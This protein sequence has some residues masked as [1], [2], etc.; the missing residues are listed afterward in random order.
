MGIP[1]VNKKAAT[2]A[3]AL[4]DNWFTLIGFPEQIQSDKGKEFV[5]KVCKAMYS[6]FAVRKVQTSGWHPQANGQVERFNKTLAEMLTKLCAK[7]QVNWPNYLRTVVMEYNAMVHCSTGE[8]PY[9]M[10]FGRDFRFPLEIKNSVGS[11]IDPDWNQSRIALI[12]KRVNKAIR[13]NADRHKENAASYNKKRIPHG[14]KKGD[15]VIEVTMQST[16]KAKG[17]HKKLKLPGKGPYKVVEI[18]KDNNTVKLQ[19]EVSSSRDSWVVNV[20]RVR[21]FV[22]RP[23][24]MVDAK[25][26]TINEAT[27]PPQV[28]DQEMILELQPENAVVENDVVLKTVEQIFKK[29]VI[30]EPQSLC[31]FKSH[32]N[33]ENLMVDALVGTRWKCGQAIK[34]RRKGGY[35]A[36]VVG[37]H[38]NAWIPVFKLRLCKC[39]DSF[40]KDASAEEFL[41]VKEKKY[42]KVDNQ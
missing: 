12:A 13:R 32:L 29:P 9:W 5:A 6:V 34:F 38:I 35:S 19:D 39:D 30:K 16:N 20:S 26:L 8:S 14:L 24:W 23:N 21:K 2:V 37:R 1:I 11:T 31:I 41:W 18:A 15:L 17:T 10:L 27:G 36:K 28:L 4:Y 33:E 40:P 42:W 22:A 7:D 3:F 25:D